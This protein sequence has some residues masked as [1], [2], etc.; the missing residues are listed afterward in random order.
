[1]ID[2]PLEANRA[3]VLAFYDRVVN[4]RDFDAASRYIGSYY[5]QH[6]ADVADG[7][8][9]LREFMERSKRISPDLAC[10]RKTGTCRR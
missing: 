9:G 3:A 4:Q 6:R 5:R 8:D 10:R 1:M 7:L 2:D